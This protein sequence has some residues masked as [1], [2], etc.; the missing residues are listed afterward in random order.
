MEKLKAWLAGLA[1]VG[2]ADTPTGRSLL[3]ERHRALKRQIPLLYAIALAN[4][5]GLHFATTGFTTFWSPS[6]LL[7][8]MV[9]GRLIYW[10]RSSKRTLLPEVILRELKRIFLFALG[11]CLSFSIWGLYLATAAGVEA[12]EK[13]YVVLFSSLAS[14]GCAYALSSFPSAARIPLIFP[15]MIVA[16]MLLTEPDPALVAVGISLSIILLISLRLL[17]IH[18]ENFTKLVESRAGIAAERERARRAEKTAKAEKAKARIV[19]DTDPLTR[20]ANRRAFLRK[21][22]REAGSL[23]RSGR[24]LALAMV[25][26]D[27][28]KP[29]N[30]TFG[31]ATGDAVLMEV[32]TRLATAGGPGTLVAR[33]GGDEFALLFRDC[34]DREAAA[35]AGR[36]I[37]DLLCEPFT[38]AGREFRIS[39]S[40][41]LTLL[42]PGDCSV[43]RALIRGDTALYRAKQNGRAGVAVFSPDMEELQQRRTRIEDALRRP[44]TR[45]SISLHFQPIFEIAS[46]RLRCFEALAR[47]QDAEMGEV[48]PAEFIPVAEQIGVI[49]TLSESLLVSA[50]REAGNWP[51]SIRLSFNLSAVQICTIG[52]ADRILAILNENRMSPDRLQIEVTETALLVDFGVA[53]D[54]LQALRKAGARIVLDDFGSGHASISY[55]REMQFDGIKLDGSLIAPVADT[56]RGRRLLKGVLDL[57]ASLGLPCVAEHIETEPQLA[58]LRE[59]GCRDGQGYLLSPPLE[60]EAARAMAASSIG[61]IRRIA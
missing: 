44:G 4:F 12:E 15:G 16:A 56:M 46:G 38:V 27:G 19:A 30:D 39:G 35:Q 2:E 7:A 45:D 48:S 29:I 58:L 37:S 40:C 54:N 49:A 31:H 24:S 33:T 41:G 59:L 10:I 47:W 50:A 6:T 32:G 28:F 13:A 9:V 21:L 61:E 26:L 23:K 1:D 53:R 3:E 20:L 60:A 34:E 36:R 5:I 43:S 52:S 17:D 11:F 51:D 57:C 14:I 55:L 42:S 25:D 18:N 22:T 8:L